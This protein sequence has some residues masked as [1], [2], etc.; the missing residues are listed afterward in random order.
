MTTL[1]KIYD[2]TCDVCRALEGYDTSIAEE[3]GLDFQAFTLEQLAATPTPLRDYVISMYVAPN[4]G[5]VDIPIYVIDNSGDL[6]ASGVIQTVEDLQNLITA[7]RQW[8]S[9]QKQP[10]AE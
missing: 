5:M 2:T 7:W 3:A 9:F 1:I 4:D 8:E 10:S 6:Q